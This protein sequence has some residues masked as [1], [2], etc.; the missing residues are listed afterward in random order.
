MTN[1]K[2]CPFCGG[3]ALTIDWCDG[4]VRCSKCHAAKQL[5]EL[6]GYEITYIWNTGNKDDK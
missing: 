5:W 3:K 1:L 2:P 6:S 4:L